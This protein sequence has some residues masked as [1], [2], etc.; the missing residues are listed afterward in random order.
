MY[1]RLTSNSLWSQLNPEFLIPPTFSSQT[2]GIQ[3]CTIVYD[4]G[5]AGNQ[6][7]GFFSC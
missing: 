1:P 2:L 7:Q 5:G 3:M 6:S 4:E